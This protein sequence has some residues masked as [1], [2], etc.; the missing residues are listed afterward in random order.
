MSP[1]AQID[2]GRFRHP[3]DDFRMAGF[4]DTLDRVNALVVRMK[5]GMS[6]KC[7]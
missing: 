2:V 3:T 6:R 4:M 1:I 5:M 7:G